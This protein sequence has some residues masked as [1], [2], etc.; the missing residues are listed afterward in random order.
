MNEELEHLGVQIRP[1]PAEPSARRWLHGAI[2]IPPL[3]DLLE[4]SNRR[5]PTCGEAPAAEGTEADAA[6]V[7]AA[8]AH[9]GGERLVLDLYP[10]G[11]SPPWPW[12]CIRGNACG[13]VEGVLKAGEHLGC[14]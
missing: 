6:A 1:L 9:Q 5:H 8:H 7:V 11:L 14:E 13:P 12:R 2:D 10:L 3:E 4:W